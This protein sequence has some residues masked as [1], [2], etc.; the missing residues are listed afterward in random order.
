MQA[1]LFE[2]IQPHLPLF[3]TE[4][5]NL[6][7]SKHVSDQAKLL[8]EAAEELLVETQRHEVNL[9][10]QVKSYKKAGKVEEGAIQ[11]NNR[12]DFYML[13]KQVD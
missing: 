5:F 6:V 13:A 4:V 12:L 10:S 11:Q 1:Y 8:N 3:N 9:R 7:D 2:H